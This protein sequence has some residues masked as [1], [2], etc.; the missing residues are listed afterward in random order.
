MMSLE[1]FG[2]IASLGAESGVSD[3][4]DN[5]SLRSQS[6]CLD[7]DLDDQSPNQDGSIVME[8]IAS[9]P[10]PLDMYDPIDFIGRFSKFQSR[11]RR[12]TRIIVGK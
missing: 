6:Q 5:L 1:D 12:R 10:L 4:G 7:Q 9:L 8:R 3:H 2:S 11:S